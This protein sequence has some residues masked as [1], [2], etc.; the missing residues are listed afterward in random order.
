MSRTTSADGKGGSDI[1]GRLSQM[2]NR[3]SLMVIDATLAA[4][5][6]D[7][8]KDGQGYADAAAEIRA[9]SR[10]MM[11]AAQDFQA[12]VEPVPAE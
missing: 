12:T 2:S 1:V 6:K 7:L 4:L 10:R 9:L 5:P 3:T 8:P 11:Q